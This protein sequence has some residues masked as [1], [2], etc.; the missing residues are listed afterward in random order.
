MSNICFYHNDI[1]GHCSGAIVKFFVP[2]DHMIEMNYDRGIPWD[3]VH[4]GDKVYMVDFSADIQ[5]MIKL[6]SM[7]DFHWIDHHKTAIEKA[8]E[9][10]F[11]PK[12]FIDEDEGL[13]GCELS[14]IYFTDSSVDE[15]PKSVRLCGRFDVWD[16]QDSEVL[17]FHYGIESYDT[18][19]LRNFDLWKE[20][21]EPKENLFHPGE[22]II[23][24]LIDEGRTIQRYVAKTNYNIANENAFLLPWEGHKFLAI[25]HSGPGSKI[26]DGLY[27]PNHHDAMLTFNR[28][29]KGEW[30]V[31]LYNGNSGK[32]DCGSIAKKYGGGGHQD[33]AG[34]MCKEL[35]FKI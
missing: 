31:G 22:N 34:F 16:H 13:A 1:D 20:L 27:N 18:D 24:R 33:S 11:H 2:I 7:T 19:P 21:L 4:K 26:F 5:D 12:G 25:N 14:W 9:A 17:P 3:I 10:D 8:N 35:P 32:V 6:N 30:R 15:L 29:K 28:S 23:E